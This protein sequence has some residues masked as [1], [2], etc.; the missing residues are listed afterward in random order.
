[1]VAVEPI[2]PVVPIEPPPA[3]EI[4]APAVLVAEAMSSVP[5]ETTP[6][7]ASVPTMELPAITDGRAA[8]VDV[9]LETLAVRVP[10]PAT[11]RPS[12]AAASGLDSLASGL[13]AA[14]RVGRS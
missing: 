4:P 8:L 14:I 7:E 10:R 2:E 13:L 3:I 11:A 9:L 1:V 6:L 5:V 12:K